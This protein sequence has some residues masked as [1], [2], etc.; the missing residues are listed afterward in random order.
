MRKFLLFDFDGVIIDSFHSSFSIN[1]K[2][3]PGGIEEQQYRDFFNGNVYESVTKPDEDKMKNDSVKQFFSHYELNCKNLSYFE[4]MPEVI[5]KLSADYTMII[6]SSTVGNIIENFLH[7]HGLQNY[8][9]DIM[10]PEIEHNKSKK[11]KMVFEKFNIGPDDCLFITD[12]L[13]DIKEARHAG[14]DSI[15]VSWGYHSLATLELGNPLAI[16]DRPSELVET[17]KLF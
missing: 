11:I 6:I 17:I 5:K 4:G 13:G 16:V 1:Q 12:T 7:C 8:F 9:S 3:R 14:V 15:A 10:G 2:I